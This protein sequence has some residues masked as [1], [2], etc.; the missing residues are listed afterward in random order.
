MILSDAQIQSVSQ[1]LRR[2]GQTVPPLA[3]QAFEVYEKGHQDYVTDIDHALDQQLTTGFRQLFPTELLITEENADSWAAFQATTERLWLIDPLD[4]TEDFIQ[5]DPNFVLMAG[6][7]VQHQPQI[8][9][10]YA[11]M[12]DRLYWGGPDYGLFQ[13]EADG[14]PQLLQPLRPASPSATFCPILL[15]H[16]DRK[17]FGEA[18]LHQLPAAQFD[19]IGSFGLKVM[20]VITGQAGIY[21]YLNGRVKLWDTTG[22]LAMARACGLMCCDLQGDPLQFTPDVINPATLAHQQSIVIGWPHYVD[23]LLPP[24]R[25]AVMNQLAQT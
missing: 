18:I 7:L 2:C 3:K 8:G 11:P 22:P 20:R 25:Q 12:F 1:L 13:A 21:V 4:G 24:I 16:K 23:T 15:G 9:W 10:I 17:R 14:L 5:G 19:C 6:L